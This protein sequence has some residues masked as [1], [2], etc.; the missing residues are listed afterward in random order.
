MI[1][2]GLPNAST[3]DTSSVTS[4]L[5]RLTSSNPSLRNSGCMTYS[6]NSKTVECLIA[7]QLHHMA[8]Q[9]TA[10]NNLATLNYQQ[11]EV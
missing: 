10:A 2:T 11:W 4:S 5:F 7:A 8:Q 1:L 9:S 6:E 3:I